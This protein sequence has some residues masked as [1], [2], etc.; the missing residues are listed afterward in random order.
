MY[1]EFRELALQRYGCTCD[2]CR[3]QTAIDE[4]KE[5]QKMQIV[6]YSTMS[7]DDLKPGDVLVATITL[8]M[9]HRLDK[10]GRPMYRM[11]C[12][13]Y[14]SQQIEDGILQG[15]RI[16]MREIGVEA[17]FPIIAGLSSG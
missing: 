8:H 15:D 7:Q 1:E 3:T 13:S 4:R 5:K 14:P 17:I 6:D 9:S 2:S 11:Y 12:C 10:N 16:F